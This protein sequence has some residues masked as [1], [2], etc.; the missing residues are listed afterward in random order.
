MKAVLATARS[1]RAKL[2]A[3]AN[4]DRD[5]A[6]FCGLAS[7]MLAEAAADADAFR[8]GFFMQWEVLYGRR[9]RYPH[10]HAWCQFG[11]AIVDVTAT[12][13]GRFPAIYV[14][15]AQ[16]T[17]R[18]IERASG[19][20]AVDEIMESWWC[21]REPEYRKLRRRLRALDDGGTNR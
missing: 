1:V 2:L 3:R 14:V 10:P 7:M 18:Y 6:G 4:I 13:F 12:Q 16:D 11:K 5:L 19:I 21:I 9:G 15:A 8:L 20:Q 17:D